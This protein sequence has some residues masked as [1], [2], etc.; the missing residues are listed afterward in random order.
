MMAMAVLF[1]TLKFVNRLKEVGVDP[2][3]A[4]VQVNV[5]AEA[6]SLI[7]Q[8]SLD[9][10]QDI[11]ELR[12]TTRQD[13]QEVR[14]EVLEVKQNVKGLEVRFDIKLK[15]LENHMLVRLGSMI[16]GGFAMMLTLMT[17]FHMH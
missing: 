5:L 8:D 4:E 11:A 1:D 12:E 2:R 14:K 15:D 6:M 13:I 3:Q 10:K 16:G 7:V 17:I 9:T